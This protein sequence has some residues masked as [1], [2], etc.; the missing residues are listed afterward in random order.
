MT[1][2]EQGIKN[3]ESDCF[4]CEYALQKAI[5]NEEGF[6]PRDFPKSHG[7]IIHKICKHCPIDFCGNGKG[8][9]RDCESP[10]NRLVLLENLA[11]TAVIKELDADR[12]AELALEVA[13]LPER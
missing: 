2:I 4:C 3:L 9:C 11:S 6:D 1:K 12:M 10:F 8:G 13:N 7:S 5:E